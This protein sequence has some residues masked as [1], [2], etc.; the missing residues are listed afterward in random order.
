MHR[1]QQHNRVTVFKPVVADTAGE[2]NEAHREPAA[3]FFVKGVGPLFCSCRHALTVLAHPSS[4][5][6]LLQ[7]CESTPFPEWQHRE[8]FILHRSTCGMRQSSIPRRAP[9]NRSST[10]EMLRGYP[11]LAS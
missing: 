4:T 7:R 9:M 8:V 10:R 6:A 2:N 3:C 5:E 1:T 11:P